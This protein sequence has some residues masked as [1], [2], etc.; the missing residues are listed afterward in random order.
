MSALR[1]NAHTVRSP[2]KTSHHN[3]PRPNRRGLSFVAIVRRRRTLSTRRTA[4]S[5]RLT[6]Y[7]S[8]CMIAD[9]NITWQQLIQDLRDSGMPMCVIAKRCDLSPQAVT[10]IGSGRTAEPKGFAA[11]KMYALHARRMRSK[12][13]AV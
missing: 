4:S 2:A 8:P 3:K 10:D 6:H 9:M 1:Y 11:V 13:K 7:G 12:K 5:R